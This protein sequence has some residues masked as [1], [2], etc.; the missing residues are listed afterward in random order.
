[1][2]L[3]I[4][5]ALLFPI[6]MFSI[7]VF[8]ASVKLI[9]VYTKWLVCCGWVRYNLLRLVFRAI[10]TSM[11]WYYGWYNAS[12]KPHVQPC[13]ECL[14][15]IWHTYNIQV[16]MPYTCVDIDNWKVSADMPRASKS[17]ATLFVHENLIGPWLCPSCFRHY[18][19][20]SLLEQSNITC[21]CACKVFCETISNEN[22]CLTEM[23]G[24]H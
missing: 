11:V 13:L 9:L 19:Y 24:F 22:W 14:P 8:K 5:W 21:M 20:V 3:I 6:L 10:T 18:C 12:T 17:F 2:V 4:F 15:F 16:I 1:M 7:F 23:S